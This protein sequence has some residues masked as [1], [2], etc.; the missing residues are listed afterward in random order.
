MGS[1]FDQASF[2]KNIDFIF[3][4]STVSVPR[5]ITRPSPSTYYVERFEPL[6]LRQPPKALPDHMVKTQARVWQRIPGPALPILLPVLRT[7][8]SRIAQ[9]PFILAGI[10]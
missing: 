7:V 1:K 2:C 5:I 9:L 4:E 10:Q 8:A 3:A 6:G